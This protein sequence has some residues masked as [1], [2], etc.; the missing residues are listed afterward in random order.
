VD[1]SRAQEGIDL[2]RAA[3]T[4]SVHSRDNGC[5]EVAFIGGSVAVRDSKNRSASPLVF[6]STEWN[7]FIDGVID[8]QFSKANID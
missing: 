7:A 3:W 5:V 8:G 4:K 2:S 6:T 1:L